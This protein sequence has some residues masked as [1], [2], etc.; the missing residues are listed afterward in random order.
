MDID[1]KAGLVTLRVLYRGPEGATK[2]LNLRGLHA[3]SDPSERDCLSVMRTEEDTIVTFPLT[4]PDELPLLGL[5]V[6][7][8]AIAAPGR[9]H[10]SAVERLLLLAADAVV[11]LPERAAPAGRTSRTALE[12]LV[13]ELT[14]CGRQPGEVPLL[15]QDYVDGNPRL[16][17]RHI[18]DE[19]NAWAP[20]FMA[21]QGDTQDCV[22]LVFDAAR[23]AVRVRV[24]GLERDLG[25]EGAR[26]A[27]ARRFVLPGGAPPAPRSQSRDHLVL[28][29]ALF[30]ILAAIGAVIFALAV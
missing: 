15:I 24:E 9:V 22:R 10:A 16:Q 12:E 21:V 19:V 4:A 3:S 2:F 5:K 25:E 6:R 26:E 17:P 20:R 13:A 11:F 23:E 1:L 14:A 27:V 29:A 28:L 8:Q 18:S 7:F 30:A